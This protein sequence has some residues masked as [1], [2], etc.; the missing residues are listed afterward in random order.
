MTQPLSALHVL[1]YD[2]TRSLGPTLAAF[3]QGLKD[4][5]IVGARTRT[6]RVIVPPTPHDPD[7]GE[8]IEGLVDLPGTGVVTTWAWVSKPRKN[9]PLQT[10]FAWAL[11]LIDGADTAML[12]VV[13]AD[14]VST[15]MRV[16]ARWSSEPTGSIKDLECFEPLGRAAEPRHE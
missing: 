5:K 7:T 12:H 9:H 15:G 6:G 16:K 3:F 8:D 13:D 4:H 11:V 10:P 14:E 1:E 2:Y